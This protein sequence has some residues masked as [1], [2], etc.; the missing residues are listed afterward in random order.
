MAKVS[1]KKVTLRK[2]KK[3]WFKITAPSEFKGKNI[4]E[5]VAAEPNDMVNR[6][7]KVNLMSLL[8]D[9]KRQN[10]NIKFKVESVNDDN[11]VCKT[12]GYELI[13]S[14]SRR[15][16]RKGA[17]KMDDSFI[18]VSKDGVKLKIKPVVVTRHRVSVGVIKALRAKSKEYVLNKVKELDSKD[19]F[20]SVIQM[21]VQRE[22]KVILNKVCPM[23]PCEIRSLSLVN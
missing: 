10:V 13:K 4:G 3:K 20:Q 23:G 2:K 15:F 19:V 9:Y 1:G 12:I 6:V 5:T 11:A 7:L 16:T 8:D 22:M 17:D 18:A 21:K 14:Q